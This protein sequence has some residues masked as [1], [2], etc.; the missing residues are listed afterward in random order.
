MTKI[1][2]IEQ[3]PEELKKKFEDFFLNPEMNR[4]DFNSR[5]QKQFIHKITCALLI[6]SF[7][8]IEYG[9]CFLSLLYDLFDGVE[10]AQAES[11]KTKE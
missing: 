7:Y 5:T 2:K 3:L 6:D 8:D 9:E 11:C 4:E 10:A 1:T